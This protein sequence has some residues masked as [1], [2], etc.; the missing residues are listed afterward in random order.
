M[1]LVVVHDIGSL[2]EPIRVDVG[3]LAGLSLSWAMID[4]PRV[5]K[6]MYYYSSNGE[7]PY[8]ALL[9]ERQSSGEVR[10]SVLFRRLVA[11]APWLKDQIAKLDNL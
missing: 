1:K 11:I 5:T 6:V 2:L 10:V 3:F 7:C 4:S 9:W 8:W